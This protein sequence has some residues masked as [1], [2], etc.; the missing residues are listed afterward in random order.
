MGRQ[1][2]RIAPLDERDLDGALELLQRSYAAE[3]EHS[4]LLPPVLLGDPRLAGPDLRTCMANGCIGAWLGRRLCGFMGVAAFF[5]FKG[6]RAA[7]VGELVHA[8]AAGT[9]K[10]AIYEA[11]Y[12][13]LGERI[14]SQGAQL[15][16]V[17]H[18][19]GD[20]ALQ[21]SLYRLGFGAILAE[22]LRDLSPIG[23]P[24]GVHVRQADDFRS[25]ID[26]DIEHRGY[27]RS[28]PIF[29]TKDISRGAA[30]RDLVEAQAGGC[31]LFVHDE[32]GRPAAYF[33][34]G[35]C[36]GK[37]EGRLLRDT[38]TA[39]VLSAYAVPG[40]R[41]SGVGWALLDACIAWARAKGHERLMVEH[42]TANLIGSAFWSRHFRPYLTI[43][44]RYVER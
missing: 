34:V 14:R 9:E 10:V 1:E 38:N 15:H 13:A 19:A 36:R 6:L 22:E 25:I 43:A 20:L 42:E 23:V 26:L 11:L 32:D 8:A 29:L 7:L 41:G 35:H 31:A 3:R 4:P 39:Q 28:P 16:I 33:M 37:Q 12:T 17:A 21:A 27:Y 2:M 5:P 44:M 40:A 24:A 18:F 30:E